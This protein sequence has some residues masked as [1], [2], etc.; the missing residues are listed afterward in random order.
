MPERQ[1]VGRNGCSRQ[2]P[3]RVQHQAGRLLEIAPDEV[4]SPVPAPGRG[5]QRQVHQTAGPVEG[6]QPG[7][8]VPVAAAWMQPS[9][10]KRV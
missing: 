1:R 10:G 9:K 3:I 6:R 8:A 7:E 2:R 4:F 5:W